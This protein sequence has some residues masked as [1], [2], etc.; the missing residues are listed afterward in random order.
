M[1]SI[2]PKRN[3]GAKDII[4]NPPFLPGQSS[5][6]KRGALYGP[7]P[8]THVATPH[9]TPPGDTWHTNSLS[10]FPQGSI[11]HSQTH[12]LDDPLSC[13]DMFFRPNASNLIKSLGRETRTSLVYTTI[14]IFD[15]TILSHFRQPVTAHIPS[16]I[17]RNDRNDGK[18]FPPTIFD[19]RLQGNDGSATTSA[20]S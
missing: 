14:S 8:N 15:G 12:Y 4:F 3:E 11:R 10:G 19:S 18:S 7:P 20:P 2:N 16:P 17:E 5:Q 13:S 6:F 9:G 1:W